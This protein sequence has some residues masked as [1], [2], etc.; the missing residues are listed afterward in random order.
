MKLARNPRPEPARFRWRHACV[1]A[2]FLVS[3]GSAAQDGGPDAAQSGGPKPA[4]APAAQEVRISPADAARRKQITEDSGKLFELAQSLKTE[5]DKTNKD[6]L[7]L[8][9]IRRADEIEKLAH[10]VHEKMKQAVV[11]D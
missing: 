2:A 1:A 3:F 10:S 5:V 8:S 4:A 6:M 7:S 11:P 9:V